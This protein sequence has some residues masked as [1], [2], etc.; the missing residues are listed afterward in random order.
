MALPI[1]KG[2][3]SIPN[4]F[5]SSL[6]SRVF[7]FSLFSLH[8]PPPNPDSDSDSVLFRGEQRTNV[9]IGP[10]PLTSS[11]ENG[12]VEPAEL[13][14]VSGTYLGGD[15]RQS[16]SEAL[17]CIGNAGGPR[18]RTLQCLEIFW[19]WQTRVDSDNLLLIFMCQYSYPQRVL[20][21]WMA[22]ATAKTDNL[23]LTQH[24]AS[25]ASEK[26][27]THVILQTQHT[28]NAIV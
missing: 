4:C 22:S 11:K 27:T 8:P 1:L 15:P 21:S 2:I 23:V 24:G 10:C 12:G 28:I 9:V 25:E 3:C 18:N 16:T 17:A 5:F 26:D 20:S 19:V 7:I 13:M 6:V 14:N